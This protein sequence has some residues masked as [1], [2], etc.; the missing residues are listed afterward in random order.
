MKAEEKVHIVSRVQNSA[1][2]FFCKNAY[3]T[4]NHVSVGSLNRRKIRSYPAV[5]TRLKGGSTLGN[6]VVDSVIRVTFS[7]EQSESMGSAK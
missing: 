7:E 3:L 2:G 4:R 1:Y 6:G 5:A